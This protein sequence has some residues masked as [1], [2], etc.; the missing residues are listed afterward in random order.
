LKY[1]FLIDLMKLVMI[2][3]RPLLSL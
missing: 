3:G 1:V 2:Q